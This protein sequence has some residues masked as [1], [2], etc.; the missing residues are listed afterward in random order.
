MQRIPRPATIAVALR[1]ADAVAPPSRPCVRRA[2]LRCD[3]PLEGPELSR[4]LVF[5]AVVGHGRIPTGD[6]PGVACRHRVAPGLAAQRCCSGEMRVRQ[7]RQIIRQNPIF[8]D[9]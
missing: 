5:G 9:S 2:A 7:K 3:K 4:S 6:D 1:Q 8:P